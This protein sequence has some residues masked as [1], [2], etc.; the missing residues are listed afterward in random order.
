M[1]ISSGGMWAA[2]GNFQQAASSKKQK[3]QAS[4]ALIF[5]TVWNEEGLPVAGVPIRMRRADDKRSRWSLVSDRRGEFAQR[6][7]PGKSEYVIWAEIK[8][9]KGEPPPEARVQVEQDERVDVSLHLT[10]TK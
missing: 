10:L 3:E 6:V 7:P 1:L 9:P 5:G 4:Y 8:Q 2:P